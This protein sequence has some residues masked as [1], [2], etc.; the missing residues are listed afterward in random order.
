MKFPWF[1]LYVNEFLLS[2]DVQCMNTTQIGAYFL[3]LCNSWTQ[4][5]PCFLPC[6]QKKI[7]SITKLSD[8]Q[9][10]SYKSGILDK[11]R[12]KGDKIYN[13]KLLSIYE[14]K[15]KIYE[16]KSQGGKNGAK[17]RWGNHDNTPKHSHDILVA[18]DSYKDK[19]KEKE[20]KQSKKKE[21]ENAPNSKEFQNNKQKPSPGYNSL[22]ET[23]K[24]PYI[25]S[26]EAGKP[27][28]HAIFSKSPTFQKL[29]FQKNFS[30]IVE[31]FNLCD[32]NY[33]EKSL[34][35]FRSIS[36]LQQHELIRKLVWLKKFSDSNSETLQARIPKIYN[37]I[38]GLLNDYQLQN[39]SNQPSQPQF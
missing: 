3:L 19:D 10:H 28:K 39:A 25:K 22:Q 33:L 37:E 27:R 12:Q 18:V 8:T 24:D 1:P 14:E 31:K 20:K 16:L 9:W 34:V 29:F 23:L 7:Q 32:H 5:E 2:T 21:K 26:S 4:K 30:S 35:Q 17:S 6:D 38:V 15:V 13:P 36:K 11:F